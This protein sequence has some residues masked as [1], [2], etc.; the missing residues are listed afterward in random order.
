MHAS[1][2]FWSSIIRAFASCPGFSLLRS[3]FSLTHTPASVDRQM[4]TL[5]KELSVPLTRYIGGFPRFSRLHPFEK[6]L[7]QLTVGQANY[8]S[9]L[10][11]VS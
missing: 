1:S 10:T 3:H 6:A 5:M 11:K 4:D 9:V 8:E 7:L 2:I